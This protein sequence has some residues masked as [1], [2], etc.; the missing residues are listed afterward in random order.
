M[1][2]ID[3]SSGPLP[4][5][6]LM[7]ENASTGGELAQPNAPAPDRHRRIGFMK[8]QITCPDDIKTMFAEE[9][10]EMFYGPEALNKFDR[11]AREADED[12]RHELEA[13]G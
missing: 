2:E 1:E 6:G 10:E 8:G 11:M 12:L 4:E 7:G 3:N 13:K 9:I 5:R